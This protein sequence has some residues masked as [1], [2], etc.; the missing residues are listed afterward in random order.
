LFGHP[1]K[2]VKVMDIAIDAGLQRGRYIGFMALRQQERAD[3]RVYPYRL[4]S[5]SEGVQN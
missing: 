4:A 1:A 5:A 3:Y 2:P